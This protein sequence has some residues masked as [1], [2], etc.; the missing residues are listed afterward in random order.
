VVVKAVVHRQM[1]AVMVVLVVVDTLL[2]VLVMQGELLQ[3]QLKVSMVATEQLLL[4]LQI[5]G[6]VVVVELELL[7]V[8]LE[9]VGEMG[10]LLQ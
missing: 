3:H 5:D 9:L 7:V 4:L 2:R 8:L 1:W 6:V 10:L